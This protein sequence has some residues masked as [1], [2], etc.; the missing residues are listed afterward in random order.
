[1]LS[2]L[3]VLPPVF[4]N[5][6]FLIFI[7]YC[8]ILLNSVLFFTLVLFQSDSTE[9]FRTLL[10]RFVNLEQ[11]IILFILTIHSQH[12]IN[13]MFNNQKALCGLMSH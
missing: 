6:N 2:A 10:Y 8:I 12:F 9:Y 7:L 5:L 4:F 13:A 1:M 3:T 11:V